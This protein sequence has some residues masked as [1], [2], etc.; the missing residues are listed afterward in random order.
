MENDEFDKLY[1]LMTAEFSKVH[2]EITELKQENQKK[3]ARLDEL[4]DDYNNL[5]AENAANEHGLRRIDE[6]LEDHET[7]ITKLETATEIG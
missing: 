1:K 2:D 3:F 5:T 6:S 7:R 4:A